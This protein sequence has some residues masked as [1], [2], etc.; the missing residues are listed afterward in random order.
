MSCHPKGIDCAQAILTDAVSTG[1]A[2]D[3][4]HVGRL[5]LSA[6]SD[7]TLTNLERLPACTC[8]WARGA[9][10]RLARPQP[11]L[12]TTRISP[13]HAVGLSG[14][15]GTD[16][17]HNCPSQLLLIQGTYADMSTADTQP[18][19]APTICN[20]RTI[21]VVKAVSSTCRNTASSSLDRSHHQKPCP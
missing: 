15:P 20:N 14:P 10:I 19:W 4:R 18:A 6:V 12:N 21:A 3:G 1:S 7:V 13:A 16:A 5:C 17:C 11:Q 2:L 8:T 9:V